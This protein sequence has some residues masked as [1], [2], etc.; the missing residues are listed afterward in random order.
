V[1]DF[2]D[3]NDYD[4]VALRRALGDIFVIAGGDPDGDKGPE[5]IVQGLRQMTIDVVRDLRQ[6]HDECLAEGGLQ[7]A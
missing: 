1:R 6:D 2:R 5:A 7:R 3:P 4:V